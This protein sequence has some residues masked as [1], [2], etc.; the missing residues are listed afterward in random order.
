MRQ[1]SI[2]I[3]IIL[4]LIGYGLH[5][6]EVGVAN[7]SPME[8]LDIV[9]EHYAANFDKVYYQNNTKEYYYKLPFADYYLTYD[10]LEEDGKFY[11][12]HLYEFVIDDEE[13]G[14]GHTVTYG[15]YAVDTKT[16]ELIDRLLLINMSN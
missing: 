3:L 1:I 14:I 7:I 15:W 10:G 6:E 13:E 5:K 2:V 8:A 11:I 16:G 9:M 12:Y 4:N